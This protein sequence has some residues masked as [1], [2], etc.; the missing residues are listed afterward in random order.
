MF[1]LLSL[2]LIVPISTQAEMFQWVDNNGSKNFSDRP[3]LGAKPLK[4]KSGYTYYQIKKV[5]DGDT[6]LLTNG[7]KVRLLGINTPEV[8]RRDKSAQA[9][10]E[11]AKRWL[12][13]KL[14]NKKV[15][16]ES[17]IEKK[18]KYGRLLAH[19]FTEDKEHINIELVKQGLASVNIYPPNLKYTDELIK[20]EQQAEQARLGI[21]GYQEYAPKPLS[22]I[23]QQRVKGWQR[24]TGVI[25]N[26]R[27][28]RR[29]I[30]LDFTDTFAL[31]IERKAEGLFPVLESYMGRPI[32]A[33][34][35]IHRHKKR[36]SMIIRHPSAIIN[37]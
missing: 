33:R 19:V 31:K 25:N 24:I 3:H 8:K 2:L 27:Y 18:D 26:I 36:Y 4:I 23:S 34:G 11:E 7:L 10:G 22:H 28:S 15:R 17:D 5:Y 35:W 9:G 6:I 21:W 30:Y 16:L 13:K 20:A 37:R 1:F 12:Q 29:Y 14:K 32:E